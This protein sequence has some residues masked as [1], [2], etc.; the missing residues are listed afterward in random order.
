[1]AQEALVI[2]ASGMLTEVARWLA[3]EGY[4]V[5]GVGR[6]RQKLASV[7]DGSG[8]PA[9]SSTGDCRTG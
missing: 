4:R 1:M 3:K 2:G 5:T 8:N 7:R 6:D 9:K